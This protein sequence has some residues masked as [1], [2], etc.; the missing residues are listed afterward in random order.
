MR[1]EEKL[2][3]V[4]RGIRMAQ[5][6]VALSFRRDIRAVRT[7]SDGEEH[8]RQAALAWVADTI[9]RPNPKLGR[10]GAVCPCT[11]PALKSGA[12]T[13]AVYPESAEVSV[14][15]L[16]RVVLREGLAHRRRV[17][18]STSQWELQTHLVV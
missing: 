12:V 18:R 15:V 10:S 13:I 6:L 5:D 7:L 1:M 17:N 14:D 4:K 9:G 2:G 16:R 8:A 3:E 11:P